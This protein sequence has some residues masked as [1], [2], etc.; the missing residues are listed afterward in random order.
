MS[1]SCMFQMGQS[2]V[3]WFAASTLYRYDVRESD[4]FVLSCARVRCCASVSVVFVVFIVVSAVCS[5][6]LIFLWLR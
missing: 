6:L 4:L 5:S 1:C 3:V 2:G